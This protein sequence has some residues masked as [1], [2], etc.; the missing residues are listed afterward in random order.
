MLSSTYVE[1]GTYPQW[2][3][4]RVEEGL[5]LIFKA[6]LIRAKIISNTLFKKTDKLKR[7][8]SQCHGNF[9]SKINK[10]YEL[11]VGNTLVYQVRII[12]RWAKVT[13]LRAL[14][15]FLEALC[16]IEKRLGGW[17]VV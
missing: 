14:T 1:Y 5:D 9:I 8:Y 13:T 16:Q 3:M 12:Q 7:I 6:Q 11:F 4:E 10:H 2:R 15:I 17:T